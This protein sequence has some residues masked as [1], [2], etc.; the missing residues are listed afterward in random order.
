M[1]TTNIKRFFERFSSDP[2]ALAVLALSAFLVYSHVSFPGESYVI[3]AADK[4]TATAY[5]KQIGPWI[6]TNEKKVFGFMILLPAAFAA[7]PSNRGVLIVAIAAWAMFIP[8]HTVWMFVAQAACLAL[9][10]SPDMRQYKIY[11][12]GA[13][14]ALYYS[15]MIYPRLGASTTTPKS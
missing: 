4:L 7:P 12:V 13:A 5:G 10:F 2:I 14:V 6:K 15:D 11:I 1:V 9:F 3:Q 8:E